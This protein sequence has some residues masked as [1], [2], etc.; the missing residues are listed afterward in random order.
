ML[1][2]Y[3]RGED[4]HTT[5]AR[6]VLGKYEVTKADR[7]LSK[8]LN[9]GLLYGMGAK[10][11]AAYAASNFG[12]ALT[13]AEAARHR[14]TFFRTYSGLRAWHR[15]VPNGM[16]QILS[17][18]AGQAQ[19]QL[20]HIRHELETNDAIHRDYPGAASVGPVWRQAGPH[21]TLQ[22]FGHRGAGYG[23]AHPRSPVAAVTTVVGGLR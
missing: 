12:V 15:C 17:D 19:D 4:L 6:A 7:Q 18:S 22:R 9:F 3:Q 13:E 11:L 10:S 20:R 14:D 23:R 2:A 16:I 5:T 1:D 21:R 8:S